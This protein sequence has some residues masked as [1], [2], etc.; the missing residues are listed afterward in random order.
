M[1]GPARNP[2]GSYISTHLEIF[3]FPCRTLDND[4]NLGLRV[5]M[6]AVDC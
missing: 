6:P 5:M 1:Q 3:G 4:P 2:D